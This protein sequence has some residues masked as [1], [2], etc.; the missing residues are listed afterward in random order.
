MIHFGLRWLRMFLVHTQKMVLDIH[1]KL[2]DIFWK[3][4]DPTTLN[5][6]GA[7]IGTQYRS[8]IFHHNE[9]QQKI[10]QKSMN[11][12][13]SSGIYENSIVTEIMPLGIF[14][15]A[16]D[17]H[18]S[19]YRVNPNAPYCRVVIKPKLEKFNQ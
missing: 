11:A 14:Y 2:L 9:K 4:H 7:D 12:A 1:K 16:E 13:D 5:Q 3:S 19:Y 15:L 6:Q 10:S 8:I 18:Q 17:Y